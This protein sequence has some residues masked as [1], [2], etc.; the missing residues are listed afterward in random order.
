MKETARLSAEDQTVVQLGTKERWK[1]VF[2]TPSESLHVSA[3]VHGSNSPRLATSP[4]ATT[5]LRHPASEGKAAEIFKH[6]HH[7]VPRNMAPTECAMDLYPSWVLWLRGQLSSLSILQ[8]R[9]LLI[10]HHRSTHTEAVPPPHGS[11]V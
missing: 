3:E 6:T 4:S 10:K 1:F 7:R 5:L 2:L 9:S 11:T 8:Q